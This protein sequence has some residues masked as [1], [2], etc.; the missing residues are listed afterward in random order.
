M[1]DINYAGSFCAHEL[2]QAGLEEAIVYMRGSMSL[3]ASPRW[4]KTFPLYI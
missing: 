4:K 3:K 2:W 1:Q